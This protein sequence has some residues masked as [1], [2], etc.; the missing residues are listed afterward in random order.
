MLEPIYGPIVGRWVAARM[1]VPMSDRDFHPYSAIGFHDKG[2][3]V[4]G[5]IYNNYYP[6]PGRM[7]ATI[8]ASRPGWASRGILRA[9]FWYPFVQ[10]R[11]TRL[12]ATTAQSNQR[13]SRLLTGLGFQLEGA[14]RQGWWDGQQDMLMF[15]MLRSECKWISQKEPPING[16]VYA[17]G[18]S[19]P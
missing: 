5:I 15:G 8:A 7:Q 12:E 3:I 1:E 10:E 4:V 2:E 6:R 18:P 16:Q 19:G 11:C 14:A 13:A 17:I 9:F